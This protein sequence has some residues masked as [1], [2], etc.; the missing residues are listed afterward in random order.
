METPPQSSWF[1]DDRHQLCLV[2]TFVLM[3]LHFAVVKQK[4][5]NSVSPFPLRD[6]LNRV[7][8]YG[9]FIGKYTCNL[10]HLVKVFIKVLF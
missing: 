8:C 10:G 7:T 2:E 1:P 4:Y 5:N 6:S 9:E 3:R